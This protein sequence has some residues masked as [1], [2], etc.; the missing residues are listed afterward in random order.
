MSTISRPA[1]SL[2]QYR[3]ATGY[4]GVLPIND[5]ITNRP[6]SRLS[7][8]SINYDDDDNMMCRPGSRQS[9]RSYTSHKQTGP[10]SRPASSLSQQRPGT[11][12]EGVFSNTGG[13]ANRPNS[14]LSIHPNDDDD[15]D[16]DIICRPESRLSVRSNT[17]HGKTRPKSGSS[18]QS[19]KHTTNRPLSRTSIQSTKFERLISRSR[20]VSCD[21][22]HQTR[23]M[24][25]TSK[26]NRPSSTTSVRPVTSNCSLLSNHKTFSSS[27]CPT[28]LVA[29]CNDYAP[30]EVLT[31]CVLDSTV[32]PCSILSMSKLKEEN[33]GIDEKNTLI[34]GRDRGKSF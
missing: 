28:K 5:N 31:C 20:T 29:K 24:S 17:S 6:S 2:S 19:H 1:S 15:D 11:G 30:P 26:Q 13:T 21:E 22:I 12:N 25:R 3:P 23:P 34:F 33:H 18:L 16:D 14:R 10:H 27:A 4:E 9:V 8:H 7:V 32:R